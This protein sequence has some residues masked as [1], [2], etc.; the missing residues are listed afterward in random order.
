MYC[1][2]NGSVHCGFAG[3]VL[4]IESGA[5]GVRRRN[6]YEKDLHAM[7]LRAIILFSTLKM[8]N[9]AGTPWE[10]RK[11]RLFLWLKMLYILL[12]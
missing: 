6:F 7:I 5:V 1:T 12:T 2:D 9:K 3:L 11:F 4:G 8:I 10:I